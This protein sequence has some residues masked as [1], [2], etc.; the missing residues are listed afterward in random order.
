MSILYAI[1]D[2][3]KRFEVSQ[4]RKLKQLAWVAVPTE[5][6]GLGFR[7]LM[8]MADGIEIFG[9]WI[10]LLQVAAKCTPRWVLRDETGPFSA[11]DLALKTGCPANVFTRALEVLSSK[12]I[13]WIITST[14]PVSSQHPPSTLPACSQNTTAT[15][16]QTIQD[17]TNTTGGA[18][19]IQHAGQKEGG[20]VDIL[21]IAD[22]LDTP[23]FLKAWSRWQSYSR[24]KGR[25][26]LLT[27]EAQLQKFAEWG[28]AASIKSIEETITRGWLK[29]VEPETMA[30]ESHTGPRP[31]TPDELK[32]WGPQGCAISNAAAKEP[33]KCS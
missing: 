21:P 8:A 6:D 26:S 29:L 19:S 17:E 14:M 10:L 24:D 7:R 13:A 3:A 18:T 31:L 28:P 5:H 11:E 23:E 2:G 33:E 16:R 1:K 27:L 22:S 9:A 25:V 15:Y 20:D 32:T 12:E 30:D 4:S